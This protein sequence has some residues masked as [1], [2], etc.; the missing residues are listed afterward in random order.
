MEVNELDEGAENRLYDG[1]DGEMPEKTEK[2]RNNEQQVIILMN[3]KL[4]QVGLEIYHNE[5]K[6]LCAYM[7]NFGY[8]LKMR[9]FDMVMEIN[10]GSLVVEQP[11][12]NSLTPN[13]QYLYLIDNEYDEGDS[14]LRMKFVQANKESPFFATEYNSTEQAIDFEFKG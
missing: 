11:Q 3:L 12:Y 5:S 9:T 7:R 6:V 4:N 14:L 8:E 2:D 13:R 1:G 10:L